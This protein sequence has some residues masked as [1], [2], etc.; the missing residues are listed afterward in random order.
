MYFL[1]EYK[2]GIFNRYRKG[3]PVTEMFTKDVTYLTNWLRNLIINRFRN[4]TIFIHPHYPSHGSTIYKVARMLHF[5]LTNKKPVKY[6]AAI[7]WEYATVRNEYALIES[8]AG[9]IPRVNLHSRNISKEY[10]DQMFLA[11]FG[12]STI[13]NPLTYQGKGVIKSNTNALHDGTI[14]DFPITEKKTGFIY[15]KLLNNRHDEHTVADIRVP[16]VKKMLPLVYI[17]YR[18]INERFKNTTVHTEI[19]RAEDIFNLHEQEQINLFC[20]AIRLDYGELDVVRNKDDGQIYIIDVNNTPQGPPANTTK[21]NGKRMI[22]LIAE[23]FEN[24][25]LNTAKQ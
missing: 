9:T 5:N 12:H 1:S 10:V 20:S 4:K 7:C 19:S 18:N 6:S 25:F 16:I 3:M 11:V 21:E 13:I 17:K 15:Q 24:E 14:V 8:L 2:R 22:N 23:Y